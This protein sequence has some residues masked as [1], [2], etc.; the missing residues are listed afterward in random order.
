MSE[1]CSICAASCG[2]AAELVDHM[3]TVHTGENPASDLDQN[4]AARTS[5]FLCALCG[6]RFP[7]A[8]AL[9]IHNLRPSAV[10]HYASWPRSAGV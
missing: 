9:G 4:P 10:G 8:Q 2:S 3:K 6:R 7:T 1:V 5:G